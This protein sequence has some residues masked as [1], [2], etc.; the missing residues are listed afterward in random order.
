MN[1]FQIKEDKLKS[2]IPTLR[3]KKRFIRIIV[4][5]NKK[6]D[7]DTLAN[8]INSQIMYYVGAIDFGKAGIR[9]LKDKF[10]YKNQEIILR[11]G[12]KF[13]DKAVG[14]IALITKIENNDV[15]LKIKRISGNLKG[16][17][18]E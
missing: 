12:T 7:F 4:K 10:D 3:Q 13:K 6:L 14:S 15:N 9:L 17:Y 18:K 1:K 5:S 11:V 16:V 2:L 8:S